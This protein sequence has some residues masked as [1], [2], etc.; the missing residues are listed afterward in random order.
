MTTKQRKA[1]GRGFGALLK[2]VDEKGGSESA[3]GVAQLAIDRIGFNPRQPRQEIDPVRLQ[4]LAQSI[5]IKGVI[6]PILVRPSS[7]SEATDYELVA[8]ERR[9]RASRLA[10][11]DKIPA[12]IRAIRDQDLLEIALIENIQRDNLSPIEEATAYRDL[13]ETQGYTQEIL[14]QRIGKNR[15][16]VANLIRLLQLPESIQLDVSGGRLSTGHARALLGVSDPTAQARLRDR[17]V[18]EQ[19][20]VRET[21]HMIKTGRVDGSSKKKAKPAELPSAQCELNQDRLRALYATRVRI[22]L[23]GVKGKIEF[24]YFSPEDFN[25]I[26]ALLIKNGG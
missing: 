26:F 7:G 10:G 9:L 21:E 22:R 8:G 1:L 20:S 23:N 12:I 14:S 17:I 5:K 19:L 2:A 25:R 16:T 4:E 6:Q 11:F 18:Q 13:L 15:S 3:A 24:D